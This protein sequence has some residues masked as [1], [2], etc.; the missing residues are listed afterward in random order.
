[1]TVSAICVS[2]FVGALASVNQYNR[3]QSVTFLLLGTIGVGYSE[4]LV[5]TSVA[6]VTDPGDIGLSY[7]MMSSIRNA[8]A[9]VASKWSLL[10]KS[11]AGRFN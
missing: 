5:L 3:H 7:G 4:S 10:P 2:T 11:F 8:G 6:L 1:M 9:A